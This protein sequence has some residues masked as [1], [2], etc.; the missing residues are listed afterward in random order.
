MPLADIYPGE[1]TASDTWAQALEAAV[2]TM[3]NLPD[4]EASIRVRKIVISESSIT[5]SYAQRA[6]A[7]PSELPDFL[8]DTF[9]KL[10]PSGPS[11]KRV[12]MRKWMVNLTEPALNWSA[13]QRFQV[14]TLVR[15]YNSPHKHLYEHVMLSHPVFPGCL[16]IRG[17]KIPDQAEPL[18]GS[19]HLQVPSSREGRSVRLVHQTPCPILTYQW[20][21]LKRIDERM[22]KHLS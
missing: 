16:V 5:C 13:E 21:D 3:F 1:F 18:P 10:F 11:L 14:R 8:S 12:G 4:I 20:G 22:P 15:L 2:A 9:K 6:G 19:P 7:T 17:P